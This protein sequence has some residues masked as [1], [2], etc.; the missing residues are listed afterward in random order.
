MTNPISPEHSVVVAD[1][2]ELLGTMV[3]LDGACVVDLGCGNGQF[4]RR[5]LECTAVASVVGFEVDRIQHERSLQ[6]PGPAGLEFRLGAA[7]DIPLEDACADGVVMMRSLHHV[8]VSSMGK[9]LRE[10]ARILKPGGWLY[11]SE[12][13]YAGDLNDVIRLFHD[14]RVV[15]EEAYAALKHASTA[16]VLELVQERRFV[17]PVVF[18]DYDDFVE[19]VVRVTHSAHAYPQEV[20]TAVRSR[21]ERAAT[22][23]GIRFLRPMRVNR[24][25]RPARERPR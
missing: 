12:P 23:L 24:L 21:L 18:R 6:T 20:A 11:V 4:A 17:T 25:R 1:E 8:P 9:A 22:P 16:G 3:R 14:E 10:I 13:E 15:R 19:K 2:V 5:L 7:E